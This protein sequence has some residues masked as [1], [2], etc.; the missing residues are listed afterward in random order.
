MVK[1]GKPEATWKTKEEEE[2]SCGRVWSGWMEAEAGV[3]EKEKGQ[4]EKFYER[5]M[6]RRDPREK[7][8]EGDKRQRDEH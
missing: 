2:N 4:R 1:F 5:A 6:G 7:V 3:R 8:Q